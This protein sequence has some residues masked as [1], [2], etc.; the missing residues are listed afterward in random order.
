[1]TEVVNKVADALDIETYLL[2]SSEEQ[3]K[4]MALQLMTELGLKNADVVFIQHLGSGARVRVRA[5]MHKPGDRYS[6][7]S[8]NKK[9]VLNNA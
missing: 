8:A 2:C 7:C 3:G 9:E 1:M 6:L 4:K 5:Y